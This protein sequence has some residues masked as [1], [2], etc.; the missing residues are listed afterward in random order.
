MFLIQNITNDMI[1]SPDMLVLLILS[2][3][4]FVQSTILDIRNHKNFH[5]N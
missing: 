1:Y 5:L 4:I 2:V 3:G